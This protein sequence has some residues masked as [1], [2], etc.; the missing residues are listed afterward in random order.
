MSEISTNIMHPTRI[1]SIRKLILMGHKRMEICM[2]MCT[3]KHN[4]NNKKPCPALSTNRIVEI[5]LHKLFFTVC[6]HWYTDFYGSSISM[7]ARTHS[8]YVFVDFLARRCPLSRRPP[9]NETIEINIYCTTYS[10]TL[11]ACALV[12]LYSIV[13]STL[14]TR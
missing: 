5:L 4:Y 7:D 6:I 12:L 8:L 11:N 13:K 14:L 9:S 1:N 2:N 10:C 3:T